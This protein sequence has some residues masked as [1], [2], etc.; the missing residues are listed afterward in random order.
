[1]SDEGSVTAVVEKIITSGKHGAY[2]VARSQEYGLVTFSLK[3]PV[4]DEEDQPEPGTQVVLTQF[5]KKPA[6]WRARKGRY[7][8]LKD[9]QKQQKGAKSR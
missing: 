9:E 4:W 6:G 8:T 2:A 5:I 3:P 7:F 1:M